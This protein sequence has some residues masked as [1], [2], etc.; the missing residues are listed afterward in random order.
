MSGMPDALQ[1]SFFVNRCDLERRTR[2]LA[3]LQLCSTGHRLRLAK[4]PF[5]PPPSPKTLCDL[6]QGGTTQGHAPRT[7]SKVVSNT[8]G[9]HDAQSVRK[10]G[11]ARGA[12]S[13]WSSPTKR[14]R[15]RA[16]SSSA[17]ACHHCEMEAS[18]LAC[19]YDTTRLPSSARSTG[20]N[21]PAARTTFTSPV[22]L[23]ELHAPFESRFGHALRH[24]RRQPFPEQ[25]LT[26]H[27]TPWWTLGAA[28]AAPSNP[29]GRGCDVER[30]G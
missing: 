3:S 4:A 18:G 29:L 22:K 21:L 19:R 20:F 15:M 14:V 11:A 12:A 16:A 24:P 1:V 27:C 23:L 2:P 13:V 25:S 30:R 28:L 8:E 7:R 9:T 26:S 10:P 6:R 5:R 17:F